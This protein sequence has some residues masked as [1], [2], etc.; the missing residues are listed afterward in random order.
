MIYFISLIILFLILFIFEF[1]YI[2]DTYQEYK[3]YS[4]TYNIIYYI[5]NFK[6]INL[7]VSNNI[8]NK[9]KDLK[10]DLFG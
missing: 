10:N 8:K 7:K 5:K 1:F 2:Y 3:E 9:F 4:F 6:N